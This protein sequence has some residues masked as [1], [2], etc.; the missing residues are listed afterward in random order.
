[1]ALSAWWWRL[2]RRPAVLRLNIHGNLP[3]NYAP[4]SWWFQPPQIRFGQSLDLMDKVASD[5]LVRHVLLTLGPLSCGLAKAH[6]LA[7]HVEKVVASGKTVTAVITHMSEQE[8]LIASR[9]T[10]ISL[11]PFAHISL[12][13]FAGSAVFV[14][15]AMEKL[16][17]EP[18]VFR[19][20]RFKGMA[21]TF[22]EREMPPAIRE[23]LDALLTGTENEF[24]ADIAHARGKSSKEARQ[25]ALVPWTVTSLK[26]AG[27]AFKDSTKIEEEHL[28]K[29]KKIV[30]EEQYRNVSASRGSGKRIAVLPIVGSIV[31]GNGR[32]QQSIGNLDLKPLLEKA[33]T[34]KTIA[35]VVLRVSS[36]GG[37]ALASSMICENIK[38][39]A[40][41][42]PVVVSMGPVA[43]SG[44]YLVST[45]ATHIFCEPYTLT[46]SIGVFAMKLNAQALLAT[47]GVSV[48][49]V[50]H[51]P[52]A[53]V[54][55]MHKKLNDTERN[56]MQ[57]QVDDI[58]RLFLFEVAS[59]RGLTASRVVEL[60]Q[61][62]VYTGRQAVELK[63]C[64]ELGGLHDA[65]RKAAELA[66]G[67]SSETPRVTYLTPPRRLQT[68]FSQSGLAR[69]L[70]TS[71]SS[72][73]DTSRLLSGPLLQVLQAAGCSSTGLT[74][75][76]NLEALITLG[77]TGEP[78]A[79]G[80]LQP[81]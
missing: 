68:M 51:T 57:Q 73:P 49:T 22:A 21:D 41:A 4:A 75:L 13:G 23:Q 36:P 61:G 16:G 15:A 52:L 46:G 31:L 74:P 34:D 77:A 76:D 28:S 9:C 62:K 17:L 48:G 58:Y 40:A 26:E 7:T 71:L 29:V 39:I 70:L 43:A 54:N 59:G 8:M 35:G 18:E 47:L 72:N 79:L 30:T 5:P 37:S 56:F 78:L 14:R 64:D 11:P 66:G 55:S 81:L 53:L 60:A 1:M 65:V 10:N 63:L 24:W 2:T 6:E 69:A 50:A 19:A 32:P 38:R 45:P 42:K 80:P 3:E 12:K 27:W 25:L 20:G 33:L 67:K 44:G